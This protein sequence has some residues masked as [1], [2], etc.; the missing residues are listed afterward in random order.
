[1]KIDNRQGPKRVFGRQGRSL[2][3]LAIAILVVLGLIFGGWGTVYAAQDAE[4]DD[5]LYPVKVAVDYLDDLI[6]VTESPDDPSTIGDR[7]GRQIHDRDLLQGM[8]G[9]ITDNGVDWGV[10]GPPRNQYQYGLLD[11]QTT[12]DDIDLPIDETLKTTQTMSGTQVMSM[13]QWMSGTL[14]MTREMS[15]TLYGPGQCVGDTDNCPLEI[16]LGY[17]HTFTS[18]MDAPYQGNFDQQP[19]IDQPDPGL[20]FNPETPP[21]KEAQEPE[22]NTGSTSEQ[23]KGGKP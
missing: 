11:V 17:T 15:G 21:V 10:D 13:T 3:P 23:K 19:V 20:G 5:L 1:M 18:G 2:I 16:P 6:T 22:G 9:P 12:L 14:S 8:S 7:S 4:P